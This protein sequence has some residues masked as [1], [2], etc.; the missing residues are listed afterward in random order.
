[1]SLKKKKKRRT[2]RTRRKKP[3][4]IKNTTPQRNITIRNEVI[5]YTDFSPSINRKILQ[6][7]T[8]Y[9]KDEAI[10]SCQKDEINIQ[11]PI[12]KKK[13]CVHFKKPKAQKKLLENLLSKDKINCKKITAPKQILAN[14]WFNVFFMVFFISDK[15]RKFFRYLREIMITGK[16]HTGRTVIDGWARSAFFHLNLLIESS[17]QGNNMAKLM[18]TN[19]IIYDLSVVL[20]TLFSKS[21]R[22][23]EPY[24]FL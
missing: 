6:Q 14:C 2:R 9:K 17:L 10:F 5:E 8:I 12:R 19:I 18:D 23:L 11:N 15:G 7:K 3:K 20:K 21:R 13:K 22:R 16:D 1:M 4:I 24:L